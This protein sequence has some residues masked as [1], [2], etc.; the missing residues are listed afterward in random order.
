MGKIIIDLPN[1]INRRY[2]VDCQEF[3]DALIDSLETAAT[4]VKNPV[5]LT[6]EDAADI[7]AAKRARKGDLVPWSEVKAYLDALD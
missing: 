2:R 1:R 3:A 6:A 5:K 4:P 7:R